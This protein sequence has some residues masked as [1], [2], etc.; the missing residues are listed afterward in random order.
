M[1]YSDVVIQ[2]WEPSKCLFALFRKKK[3]HL[4]F[5][6]MTVRLSLFFERCDSLCC[7]YEIIG[8]SCIFEFALHNLWRERSFW[9]PEQKKDDYYNDNELRIVSSISRTSSAFPSLKVVTTYFLATVQSSA[10]KTLEGGA[11]NIICLFVYL[12][13]S[14][15]SRTLRRS[16]CSENVW[17]KMKDKRYILVFTA[18]S[19]SP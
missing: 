2:R 13:I 7:S 11:E 16:K 8:N 9:V 1:H 6:K 17:M 12:S 18:Q 10:G 4:L 19:V 14:E 3:W 15:K 5:L